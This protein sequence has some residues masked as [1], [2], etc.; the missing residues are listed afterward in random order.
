MESLCDSVGAQIRT[1]APRSVLRASTKTQ[2]Q[3]GPAQIPKRSQPSSRIASSSDMAVAEAIMSANRPIHSTRHSSPSRA[4]CGLAA[5]LRRTPF[6]CP[7]GWSGTEHEPVGSDSRDRSRWPRRPGRPGDRL[8]GGN[9]GDQRRC[10]RPYD[11][12]MLRTPASVATSSGC[13]LTD[14]LGRLLDQA[15]DRPGCDHDRRP[16]RFDIALRG[17]TLVG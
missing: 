14:E 6:P 11:P 10:G 1:E 5:L 9:R 17:L 3:G 4:N 12:R 15:G 16:A 2:Q 7:G 8:S 13:A